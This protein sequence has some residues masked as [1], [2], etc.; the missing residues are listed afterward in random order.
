MTSLETYLRGAYEE[1]SAFLSRLLNTVEEVIPLFYQRVSVPA[2]APGKT[3]LT[4]PYAI[5]EEKGPDKPR[6][7]SY[8][9]H[10][11]ILFALDSFSPRGKDEHSLLLGKN[12]RPCKL[13]GSVVK[14]D[15]VKKV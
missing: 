13:T 4:W 12:F 15:E 5:S 1:D 9:T 7:I 10:G 14:A 6:D 11:M 3:V 8:S 2:S